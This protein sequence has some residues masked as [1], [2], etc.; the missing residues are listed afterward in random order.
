MKIDA[1]GADN[2]IVA[3]VLDW[4][5]AAA[6]AAVSDDELQAFTM[7]RQLRFEVVGGNTKERRIPTETLLQRLRNLAYECQPDG[8]DFDCVQGR[9][10]L[11]SRN[12]GG[13]GGGG[14]GGDG[15]EL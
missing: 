14:G 13:N 6:A 3:E 2:D 5:E 9:V 10:L 7:P 4:Y 1:E 8:Q 15:V 11:V 12:D